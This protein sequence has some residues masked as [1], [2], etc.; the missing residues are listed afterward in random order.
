MMVNNIRNITVI[1]KNKEI[2]LTIN[3]NVILSFN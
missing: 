3:I 1:N 2:L